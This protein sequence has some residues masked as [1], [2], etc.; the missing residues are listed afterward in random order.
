M[1]RV[2]VEDCL[3][4]DIKN[5]FDL[6]MTAAKRARQIAV[7]GAEPMVAAENDKP[8]VLALREISEGLVT[9]ASLAAQEMAEQA[10]QAY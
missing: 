2:T 10:E 7:Q 6:V 1:A 5:R 9:P 4:S 3:N 8:T